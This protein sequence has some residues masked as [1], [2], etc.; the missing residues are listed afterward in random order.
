MTE[1]KIRTLK[2]ENFKCHEALTVDFDGRSCALYGDNGTGKTGVCDAFFWLLF[3]KDSAGSDEKAIAIKPLNPDG[4]TRDPLA[5]TAVE[6]VFQ[7]NGQVLTLRRTYRENWVSRRGSGKS[8]YEGN[9]CGYYVDGVPCKKA[10]FQERVNSIVDEQRFRMLTSVTYVAAQMGWQERRALLFELAGCPGDREILGRDAR[11]APLLSAMGGLTMDAFKRKLLAEKKQLL[12]TTS[13]IPARI[14]EC[15]KTIEDVKGVDFSKIRAEVDALRVREAAITEE[16]AKL[17]HDSAAE[18][19][20]LELGQAELA[21]AQLEQE[22]RVYRD[23]Q[24][25]GAGEEAGLRQALAAL[26]GHL[27]RARAEEAREQAAL[28]D[29]EKKLG[30][31]R[32]RRAAAGAAVFSGGSCPTCGQSL[33]Q[34]RLRTAAARFEADKAERL[35]E[36]DRQLAACR[37]A[38]ARTKARLK[39]IRQELRQLGAERCAKEARLIALEEGRAMIRDMDGY[40]ARREAL[41]RKIDALKENLTALQERSSDV[42]QRLEQERSGIQKELTRHLGDLSRESL[43]DYA[44]QREQELRR[45]EQAAARQLAQAEDMLLLLED[46]SRFKTRFVEGSVNSLFRIARFRLFR[47]QA[48]GGIEERCD[49]TYAGVPY[50]SV[51][52]AMRVNLGIDIINT[53][54]RCCETRVPLFLDNAESVTQ[55]TP[56]DS[57]LIRLIVSEKDKRLRL[58]REA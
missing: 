58:E 49:V 7:V 37:E 20:R 24:C 43:L 5:V 36:I 53:L 51:N 55:V 8:E 25:T 23:S 14:S 10:A 34:A 46:Y 52:S 54:S 28:A 41:C 47:E 35:R 44:R 1:L 22:N 6:G 18:A 30:Q 17:E 31:A 26:A 38:E 45:Q 16:I 42:R 33:P 32:E 11:F 12:G 21:L 15:Q 48:N 57:Q 39:S 2:L 4:S 19:A 3:G 29:C 13:D 9:T 50:I 40:G 56:C 27:E